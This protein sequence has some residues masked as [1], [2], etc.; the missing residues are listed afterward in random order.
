MKTGRAFFVLTRI[1]LSWREGTVARYTIPRGMR[2]QLPF[3][4]SWKTLYEGLK[5]SELVLT[6]AM[7]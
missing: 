1:G 2:N 6:L 7:A 3:Y 4:T 5:R